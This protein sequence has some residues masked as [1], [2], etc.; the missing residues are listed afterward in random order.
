VK[1]VKRVDRPGERSVLTGIA[2]LTIHLGA[3]LALVPALFSW[4]ALALAAA[5]YYLTGGLGICLG[6]HRLLTHRSLRVPRLV[7]YALATLGTLALQGGPMSWVA[8]HRAHHA[9]SDTERDPHNSRRGFLW[10]HIGWL[11]RR[12][13]ARLSPAGVRH[14][15]PD[16]ERHPYYRFLEPTGLPLQ[17]LL[18]SAFFAF[19]GWPCVVWGIFVR[20]VFTYHATWLVNSAAHLAGYRTFATPGSDRSTNNRWVSLFAWGEGWHNNHHAFPFSARHGLN[21]R[22]FDATWVAIEVLRAFGLASDV[23]VPSA[24]VLERALLTRRFVTPPR[25]RGAAARAQHAPGA[26]RDRIVEGGRNSD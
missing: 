4:P 2:L 11:Y 24:L 25:S 3:C 10:S 6:Y 23:R 18:G 19:G 7:E 12:N 13:A 9:Y 14:F 22:E 8:A 15:A 26:D 1:F 5:F 20:L 17:L 16:L 21:R